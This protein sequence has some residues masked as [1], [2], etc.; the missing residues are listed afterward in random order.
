M[1]SLCYLLNTTP[2]AASLF[3]DYGES[4]AFS[5]SF[6]GIRNQKLLKNEEILDNTGACDLSAY[7][8]FTAL[9]QVVSK[10]STLVSPPI[11]TQDDF[12]HSMGIQEKLNIQK[13][14]TNIQAVKNQL[15]QEYRFLT[16][17]DKMGKN[18][19]AMYIHKSRD[20][21]IYPFVFEVYEF[22]NGK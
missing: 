15:D 10:F 8:N 18:F 20:K 17:P 5:D 6:R 12:L 4:H 16:S 9:Q 2:K 7:I 3:I 19:K 1:F 13:T 22:L 11:L 14:K 21:P